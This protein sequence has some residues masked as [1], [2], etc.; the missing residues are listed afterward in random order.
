MKVKC[1]ECG[2]EYDYKLK[3]C[4]NCGY[5]NRKK[6]IVNIILYSLSIILF[7][8]SVCRCLELFYTNKIT[9]EITETL[10]QYD[11]VQESNAVETIVDYLKTQDLIVSY[12]SKTYSIVAYNI[13]NISICSISLCMIFIWFGIWLK[14]KNIKFGNILKYIAIVIFIIFQLLPLGFAICV[15]TRISKSSSETTNNS[16]KYEVMLENNSKLIPMKEY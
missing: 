7:I 9:N 10:K 3:T 11:L 15:N 14:N 12:G 8:I 1:S 4:S 13:K 2:K 6:Q 5:T 16:S